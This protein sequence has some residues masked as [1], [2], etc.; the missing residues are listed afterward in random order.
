MF[1]GYAEF[2]QETAFSVFPEGVFKGAVDWMVGSFALD[3]S[4]GRTSSNMQWDANVVVE[5]PEAREQP[6]RIGTGGLFGILCKAAHA[7]NKRPRASDHQYVSERPC[8]R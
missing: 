4:V 5:T 8:R 2:Q 6:V 1:E 3:T 7:S